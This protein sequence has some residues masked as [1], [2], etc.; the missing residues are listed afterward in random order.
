MKNRYETV[1]V[2]MCF[3]SIPRLI[4]WMLLPSE[5]PIPWG[6]LATGTVL[7]GLGGAGFLWDVLARRKG[8]K[9]PP[10]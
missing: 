9:L 5:P 7:C 8:T 10:A 3:L 2:A 6:R 1:R 4:L